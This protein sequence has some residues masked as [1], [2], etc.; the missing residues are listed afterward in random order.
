MHFFGKLRKAWLT[1]AARPCQTVN[2][3]AAARR[4]RSD[5][6]FRALWRGTKALTQLRAAQSNSFIAR[7]GPRPPPKKKDPAPKDGAPHRSPRVI[8]SHTERA[9]VE[10][11]QK[12]QRVEG[13]RKAR[14]AETHRGAVVLRALQV[15]WTTVVCTD[16]E[17]GNFERRS[18]AARAHYLN[19][20]GPEVLPLFLIY[21][22]IRPVS[23]RIAVVWRG[24]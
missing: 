19:V 22:T 15:L 2:A 5:S 8:M 16:V 9:H 21:E 20:P 18:K 7:Q 24:C 23:W 13:E 12:V 6:K 10:G 17:W 1:G 3:V 11:P 14:R 4:Q